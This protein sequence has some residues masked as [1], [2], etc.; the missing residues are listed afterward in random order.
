MQT[1]FKINQT[2]KKYI[3]NSNTFVM[4]LNFI[5]ILKILCL[6]MHYKSITLYSYT[7]LSNGHLRIFHFI[8]HRIA[9]SHIKRVQT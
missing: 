3:E 2:E 5:S 7:M 4:L 9:I 1:Y 6:I 8:S